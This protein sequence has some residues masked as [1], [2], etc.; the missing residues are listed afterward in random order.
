MSMTSSSCVSRPRSRSRLACESATSARAHCSRDTT[1]N[2]FS[3]MPVGGNRVSWRLLYGRLLSP[4]HEH[5]L[6]MADTYRS[7]SSRRPDVKAS[8][9]VHQFSVIVLPKE[10]GDLWDTAGQSIR[11]MPGVFERARSDITA[12][13][14]SKKLINLAGMSSDWR[15]RS[16]AVRTGSFR[17]HDALRAFTVDCA[18]KSQREDLVAEVRG[19]GGGGVF[20][21]YQDFALALP[22]VAGMHEPRPW[23]PSDSADNAWPEAS[24]IA[25]AHRDGVTG[26][27]TT[28]GM[29]DTGV[30][31]DH[32][33]FRDKFV[34][35]RHVPYRYEQR[36][37]D[38]RGYDT[39]GHGSHVAAILSGRRR[40]IAPASELCAAYVI[41]SETLATSASRVARG[42]DWLIRMFDEPR[43]ADRRRIINLSL[44]FDETLLGRSTSDGRSISE[45]AVEAMNLMIRLAVRSGQAAIFAAIG[46]DGRGH[47]CYPA[48]SPGVVSVGAVDRDRDIQSFSATRRDGAGPTLHGYGVEILSAVERACDGSDLYAIMSGTSMATPYCAAVAALTWE[49]HPYLS[50]RELV[51]KLIEDALP[52]E[53]GRLARFVS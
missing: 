3:I 2:R 11:D 6:S 41:E 51:Q 16:G 40:G 9:A 1:Q 15:T 35:F 13:W 7:V 38:V 43:H 20:E 34:R 37:R 21:V 50:A 17:A 48:L 26:R 4:S 49:T 18:S 27:G 42:L 23:Q 32:V 28:F 24:G 36:H 47:A 31:A 5:C 46:N 52:L 29:L 22:A 19:F 30:D 25:K 10:D 53:A 14:T 44:G 8:T 33:E 39:S 12:R 45:S